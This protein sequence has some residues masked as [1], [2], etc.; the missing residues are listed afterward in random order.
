M[1]EGEEGNGQKN[2]E[3]R[4]DYS[5][6]TGVANQIYDLNMQGIDVEDFKTL[7]KD[8]CYDC[9]DNIVSILKIM[10]GSAR[11]LISQFEH[12]KKNWIL[13]FKFK[14]LGALNEF[15]SYKND[16]SKQVFWIT[17][18]QKMPCLH[19]FLEKVLK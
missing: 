18:C 2:E 10:L 8:R 15:Q 3:E 16:N 1:A 5:V 19:L 12:L 4:D 17:F 11:Y 14:I 13:F 9:H 7:V 6:A